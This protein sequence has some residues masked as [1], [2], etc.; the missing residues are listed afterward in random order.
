MEHGTRRYDTPR[1]HETVAQDTEEGRRRKRIYMWVAA[2]GLMAVAQCAVGIAL[3]REPSKPPVNFG[4]VAAE[5]Y[6]TEYRMEREALMS[7]PQKELGERLLSEPFEI[8][9]DITVST[10][11]LAATLGLPVGK[12]VLGLDAKYDLNDLGMKVR[13]MG[14]EY[15]SAY[16]IGEDVMLSV[17]GKAYST[18]RSLSAQGL[19]GSMGLGDR[20]IRFMPL[21]TKDMDFYIRLADIAAQSVPDE[22]TT[23]YDSDAFSPLDGAD[24][25]MTVIE[26][27]LAKEAI[28]AVAAN[29][30]ARL[31]RDATLREQAEEMLL[32]AAA[33]YGF[34][35]RS[36]DKWLAV[37][38]DGSAI[39]DDFKLRWRVY[40]RE[41]RYVGL[42]MQTSQG[43][44]D[45]EYKLLSELNGRE[46]HEAFAQL[47]NGKVLQSTDYTVVYDDGTVKLEGT[48]RPDAASV[49]SYAADL[50]F[51]KNGDAYKL[52]GTVDVDGPVLGAKPQPVSM[53]IDAK[54]RTGEGLGTMKESR[55]WQDVY[56]EKRNSLTA[57]AQ[58]PILP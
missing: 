51:E 47:V 14:M 27:T 18:P 55:G 8:E 25:G 37:V 53:D 56:A 7:A 49:F 9:A 33:F 40:E 28:Q 58:K 57:P 17:M 16:L 6:I 23:V 11:N 2:G 46:S 3:L 48:F 42:S 21:L 1:L 38:A 19:E 44:Q 35:G 26:T 10:D 5:Q 45:T 12:L 36:L 13:M 22:Y 50:A 15:A 54:I 24:A 31:Q 30:D 20:L 41:G 34:E 32:D 29:M 52:A 43:G 4:A 39:P